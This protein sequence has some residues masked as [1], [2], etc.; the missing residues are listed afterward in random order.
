LPAYDELRR[1]FYERGAVLT[2]DELEAVYKGQ[3]AFTK[4]NLRIDNTGMA[5]QEVASRLSPLL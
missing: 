3:A 5:P 1:R 2:E 4:Y